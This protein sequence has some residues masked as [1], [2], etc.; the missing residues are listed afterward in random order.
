MESVCSAPWRNSSQTSGQLIHCSDR[1]YAKPPVLKHF[2][3][4]TKQSEFPTR[5]K[6]HVYWMKLPARRLCWQEI[7]A[8]SS[9]HAHR[10]PILLWRSGLQIYY[11]ILYMNIYIWT[12]I[13]KLLCLTS[14]ACIAFWILSMDISY[15][16]FHYT[17][18]LRRIFCPRE[19]QSL[20][21]GQKSKANGHCA[22]EDDPQ[23]ICLD[24]VVSWAMLRQTHHQQKCSN[25]VQHIWS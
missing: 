15:L 20:R 6:C 21:D 13:T 10:Y 14:L 9:W 24:L 1:N 2:F 16:I 23:G 25:L 5:T 17:Q 8:G 4:Y 7:A 11:F 12:V 19:I 18:F 3:R 22:R